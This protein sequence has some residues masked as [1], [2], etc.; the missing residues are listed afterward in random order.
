[1]KLS[2]RKNTYILKAE[3]MQEIEGFGCLLGSLNILGVVIKLE[4]DERKK[5]KPIPLEERTA[6]FGIWHHFGFKT[7]E[8]YSSFLDAKKKE[9]PDFSLSFEVAHQSIL[10][11]QYR[12]I[13][14]RYNL[15]YLCRHELQ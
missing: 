2:I 5:Y 12:G 3:S 4:D 7:E 6:P 13:C 11:F 9:D 10:L 14:N 8:E 15:M 1:M